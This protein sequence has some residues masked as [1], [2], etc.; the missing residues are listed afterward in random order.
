MKI[1]IHAHHVS[2]TPA[3]KEYVENKLSKLDKFFH[4]I[5]SIHVDLDVLSNSKEKDRHQVSVKVFVSKN[6]ITASDTSKD[7][8]A[9]I[10]IVFE[11][12]EKQL[13]KHKDKL[14]HRVKTH[15]QKLS[16]K[17]DDEKELPKLVRFSEGHYYKPKPI[18]LE[19]A[20]QLFEEKDTPL[21]VYKNAE[22]EQVN[23]LFHLNDQQLGLIE[24]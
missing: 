18:Y 4:N 16:R 9:T 19:D 1:I 11:K 5:Q 22:T 6:V 8:Y 13:V 14:G 24:P 3:I 23:V 15:A 20:I 17:E 2:I 21:F 12:L 10:D 7:M